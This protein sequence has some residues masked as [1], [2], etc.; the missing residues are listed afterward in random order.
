MV[1]DGWEGVG[2]GTGVEGTEVASAACDVAVRVTVGASA[3]LPPAGCAAGAGSSLE[4]ARS[5]PSD[6]SAAMTSS[7]D[8]SGRE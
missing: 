4:H 5:A 3:R 8:M 2:T 7:Y 1:E 6:R